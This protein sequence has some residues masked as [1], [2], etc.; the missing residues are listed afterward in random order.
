MEIDGER[1]NLAESQYEASS[2]IY[3]SNDPVEILNALVN[4]GGKSF[5]EA[6][7]ALLDPETQIL[8]VIAA[9][10][11]NGIHPA[12]G[13]RRL[14]EYPAYE[15]LSAVEVL[16]VPDV[17]ADPFLT[18]QER[19]L[20][21]ERG[22]GALLVIPL[23]VAQRLIGVIG[24]TNP[25]PIELVS[26]RLRAMRNLG[27]QIAV[28]FENQT[29]LR[30]T[31]T[32]LSEVQGLYD[33]NRAMLGAVTPL[34]V[35]R[36]LRAHLAEDAISLT[37]VTVER[38]AGTSAETITIRQVVTPEAEQEV[39]IPVVGMRRAADAFGEAETSGVV[40]VED[41][42]RS[43]QRT[44]LYHALKTEKA[45]SYVAIVIRR[46]GVIEDFIAVAYDH[47]QVFD[48]RIRRLYTA[49]ADQIGVVLQNQRLLRTAQDSAA[50]FQQ[51][52]RVL[53]GLN[54]LSAGIGSFQTERDLLDYAAQSLV[55][56]IG[57]DHVGIALFEA[58]EE[59]GSVVAEFPS[60]GALGSKVETRN[61]AMMTTLRAYP[62]RAIVVPDITNSP[63]IEPDTRD[64]L[65]RI[66]VSGIML[67]ALQSSGEIVGTVGFDLYNR[68][69]QFTA[70][71]VETAQ[72]MVSQIAIGLQNI[73]LLTDAQRRAE[74]LQR[75]AAF[76]Q[77]VQA[78]LS[79]EAILQI[80]L[81]ESKHMVPMDR[82]SIALYDSRQ[83]KLRIVGQYD[84]GKTSVDIENGAFISTTGT[85]VGQVWETQE[86]VSIHDTREIPTLASRPQQDLAMRSVMVAPIRSRGRLLGTVTVACLL[87]YSYS[88]TDQPI[89]QQMINGLAV[90]IE[91]AEAYTQSQRAA[92]NEALINEIATHFQQHTAVEDM[93]QIAISEL[94]QALGARRARIRLSLDGEL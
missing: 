47:P 54:R 59:M 71:M 23:V 10:D 82:M 49:V 92:R 56:A 55:L 73:R 70:R 39:E 45:R 81:S 20:L 6:H 36:V 94:G 42:T 16:Y 15:T 93:L 60:H 87:P 3:G 21:V 53:E 17:G 91:N 80:A 67:T 85:F 40:F 4:F 34:D 61:S 90:A 77:A 58:R 26:H 18:T 2:T 31:A 28:V 11:E 9:R 43:S 48:S 33:I 78:T 13:A 29:L 65:Q 27:D 57:V 44:L 30:H 37:H 32:T 63:L 75:I 35:L 69:S 19:A 8:N 51:Q 86:M 62:D 68:S 88:V 83:G 79:L 12:Q 24:F 41:I 74:Q 25:T 1:L 64:L 89:F 46:G 38:D 5:A 66:G 7:L 50:Q 14:D 52:V 76:G 22:I 84:E 72:T